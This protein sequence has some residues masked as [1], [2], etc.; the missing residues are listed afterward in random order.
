MVAGLR[1]SIACPKPRRVFLPC[2]GPF[3]FSFQNRIVSGCRRF[4]HVSSF[5]VVFGFSVPCT[6][7]TFQIKT[8]L[9]MSVFNCVSSFVS[10]VLNTLGSHLSTMILLFKFLF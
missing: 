1:V 2:M 7:L 6:M 4:D 8:V 3:F 10:S 9:I 5:Q